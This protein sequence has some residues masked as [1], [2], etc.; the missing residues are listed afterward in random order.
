MTTSNPSPGPH[1]KR[2]ELQALTGLRAIAALA[3]VFSHT[4]APKNAPGWIH[5]LSSWGYIGVPLFFIL[6]G[7]VLGY[8]YPELSWHQKR[9]TLKF[10]IARIARVMPLYWVMIA[11]CVAFYYAMGVKQFPG[12]FVQNL[13][14]VQTWGGDLLTAQS[15]Y[16][17]PGWSIGVEM[18]FYA[19]FPLLMPCVAAVHRRWKSQ[20]MILLVVAMCALSL[21]LWLIFVA[22]GWSSLPAA[23]AASAHR[24]LYRNPLPRLAEFV[25]GL[26]LARLFLQSSAVPTIWHHLIQTATFAYTLLWAMFHPLGNAAIN[27]GSFSALFIA[28]F[29]LGIWSLASS[30]GWIARMLSLK[31]FVT[32]GAASF[33]LY[34]THRW[35]IWQLST[36]PQIKTATGL[37]PY[38]ALLVTIAVLLVIAEGAHRYVELP[39]RTLIVNATARWTHGHR[40]PHEADTKPD[41]DKRSSGAKSSISP[42]RA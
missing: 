7:F 16:N 9:R 12:A 31:F 20:G 42:P 35:I 8:N 6:S 29:A 3:V 15:R 25:T 13:F 11:Y 26:A 28:P 39:S 38:V 27:S 24:W 19:L 5:G 21:T 2:P 36:G 10:Y 17:G 33:S 32:L 14:A 1:A 23:D 40:T 4:G 41:S 30:R 22:K 37:A 18:F 34:L